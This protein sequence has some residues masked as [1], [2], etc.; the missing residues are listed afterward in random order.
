MRYISTI[1]GENASART[2]FWRKVEVGAD[3]WVWT[4]SKRYGYGQFRIGGEGSANLGAH[5]VAYRWLVGEIPLGLVVDHLCRNRACVNPDHMELVTPE[6]NSTRGMI[7]RH[8]EIERCKNG[9]PWADNQID[10][11]GYRVCAACLADRRSTP[12]MKAYHRE[13]SQGWNREKKAQRLL[14]R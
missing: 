7:S 14:E 12:G 2:R 10:R 8:A 3:C 11:Y 4:A 1:Q 6:E 13:Y 5:V 9:H